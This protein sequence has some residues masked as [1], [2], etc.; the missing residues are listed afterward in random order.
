MK[1]VC[2]TDGIAFFIDAQNKTKGQTTLCSLIV[3]MLSWKSSE[4]TAKF[5]IL[6][7]IFQNKGEKAF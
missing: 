2:I 1:L 4:Q 3:P 5:N 7:E 6:E